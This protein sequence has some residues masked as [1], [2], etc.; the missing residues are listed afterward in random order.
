MSK[1]KSRDEVEPS[2]EF[3][4]RFADYPGG[5]LLDA[6]GKVRSLKNNEVSLEPSRPVFCGYGTVNSNSVSVR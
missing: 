4:N 3:P 1:R 5:E 6:D 2:R